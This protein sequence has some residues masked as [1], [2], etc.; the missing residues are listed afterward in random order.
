MTSEPGDPMTSPP[1]PFEPVHA[2][3][4][5][6]DHPRRG[7]AYFDGRPHA[8]ELQFD[9]ERDEYHT[10]RY[11][12]RPVD[13]ATFQLALEYRD[14]W[15]RWQRALLAG[16]IALGQEAALPGDRA[17]HDELTRAL[18]TRLAALSGPSIRA[19]ASFR[20]SDRP[21]DGTRELGVEVQWTPITH[22]HAP[23]EA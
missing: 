5:T 6:F 19:R 3:T 2:I 20:R 1:R 17:R 7:V 9:T 18:D 10:D 22:E 16:E 13:D 23:R 4:D 14:I 15:F 21:A 12:L 8:F 11:A